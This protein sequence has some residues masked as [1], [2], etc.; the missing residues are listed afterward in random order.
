M[1]KLD[2]YRTSSNS[3]KEEFDREIET[4]WVTAHKRR[5]R[6]GFLKGPVPLTRLQLAANLPG[7][8]LVTYIAIRH[9]CDIQRGDETTLPTKY[10]EKWGVRQDAKIR[11]Q[12]HLRRAGLITTI[13]K[14]GRTT[15]I[16]L[17]PDEGGIR[18][19]DK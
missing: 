7:K 16:R 18:N 13:R 2:A 11:A 1:S 15:V 17:M 4:S 19:G 5:I 8:A 12:D 10:M 3:S 9:R 14:P 6:G